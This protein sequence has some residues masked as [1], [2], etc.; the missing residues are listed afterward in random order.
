MI[1]K[2]HI[3]AVVVCCAA[4]ALGPAIFAQD[5]GEAP[6][7]PADEDSGTE[8][9]PLPAPQYQQ[10]ESKIRLYVELA[11]GQVEGDPVNTSISTSSI[12]KAVSELVFDENDG[13]RA[14]L[15]WKLKNDKGWFLGRFEGYKETS[16]SFSSEG[17]QARVVDSFGDPVTT[18]A[19]SPIA[20]WIVEA[21]PQHWTAIKSTPVWDL[22]PVPPNTESDDTNG[23]GVPDPDEVRQDFSN[24]DIVIQNVGPDNLQNRLQVFDAL[25]QRDF[26]GRK[27]SGRWNA[28]MRY[29]AYE[30]NIVATTWVNDATA[31]VGFSDG[32]FV[33]PLTFA[34][35]T[36]GIGPTGSLE[37][38]MTFFR[39]RFI[40]YGLG[41]AAF[42]LQDVTTDSGIFFT[43]VRDPASNTLVPATAQLQTERSK[44]SWH[45]GLELGFQI[46]LVDQLFFNLFYQ[47][48]AYQDAILLPTN[49]II[50]DDL[51]SAPQGTS[52]VYSTQDY[53][54]EGGFVGLSFQF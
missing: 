47:G 2:R 9:T 15:G 34:Q 37:F 22:N 11:Y 5:T 27:Y 24:P 21:G 52:G 29:F 50:P 19:S 39:D 38:R 23:N 26:G 40:I 31:G 17:R 42:V 10:R 7:A 1:C 41:R 51:N 32:G 35:E 28:G 33:K 48:T 13:G 54:I 44:A 18:L 20:W 43:I 25:Y 46:R 16:F 45:F 3:A 8:A 53:Q 49:I 6:P 14:I 12:E 4:V 30:G 36:T